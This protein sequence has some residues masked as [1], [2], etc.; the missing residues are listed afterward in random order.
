MAHVRQTVF[1]IVLTGALFTAT[2]G[3][4]PKFFPDDPIQVMPAPLPVQN[5]APKSVDE[6]LDLFSSHRQTPPAT[7]AGAVNTLGDVPDSEWFTNRHGQRRMS[8]DQLREGPPLGKYPVLPLTVISGKS[9]GIMPGFTVKDAT[10]RHFYIKSDPLHY[11]ELATGAEVI[12]SKFMYAIGYNVPKNDLID[13]KLTDL[14]LAHNAKIK[15]PSGRPRKMTWSDVDEI[16]DKFPHAP[17]GSARIVASLAIEGESIGPFMYEGVR[18]DDPNDI[19]PHQNRRDLRGLY[20]FSAWLNNTDMKATNTL[21]T[22]VK[23]NGV[24]FIRHHLIDFS[25][26]LGSDGDAPKD[27]RLGFE[28]VLP[29]IPAA[30]KQVFTLGVVPQPWEEVHYPKL[31]GVGN[32]ESKL[33]NPNDWKTH[34]PNEAF[35]SRLNDD[36]YWAAKQV[37]AFTNDDIRAIVET[38]KY[39]E[40]RSTDYIVRT[41]AERRDKIGRTFFAQILPLDNFFV[42]GEDL[43]FDDLAVRYRFHP[44]R[45]YAVKWSRFDN[46]TQTHDPLP[47]STS[48]QLPP[49]TRQSPS[50]SYFCAAISAVG[51]SLKPVSVYLRKDGNNYKVV[52]IDRR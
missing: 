26:A 44:P 32:F 23:E 48:T 11:P 30:F 13:V 49:E 5:P 38:A 24:P 4:A 28:Y 43:L 35:I 41:L 39:R 12:V 37:M 51:D 15:R 22:V 33:F 2:G 14:R 29:T 50:G 17:D 18:R 27:A 31:P 52:G 1:W 16:L 6:A 25:S 42:E 20:V 47:N 45:R 8:L 7:P 10:G 9:D 3:K 34:R 21:D 19:V 36:D 46:V 40:L